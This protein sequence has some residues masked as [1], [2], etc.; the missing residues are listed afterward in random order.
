MKRESD[1]YDLAW[2]ED[3]LASE[4]TSE[5]N[6]FKDYTTLEA[7][8]KARDVKLFFYRRVV[9]HLPSEERYNLSEQIRRAAISI[10]ANLAEGYC[11]FH[12][13]EAIQFYRTARGSVYELKDHLI[14]CLDLEFID[15]KIYDEGLSLIE[16]AK[17]TINGYIKYTRQKKNSE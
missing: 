14:S 4:P 12:Y 16:D 5:Y 9:P 6:S 3:F 13:G 11:R 15:E 7:W 17:R 1:N 10:T 8:K 2:M